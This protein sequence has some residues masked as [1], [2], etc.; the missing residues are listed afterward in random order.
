[1][2]RIFFK[3]KNLNLFLICMTLNILTLKMGEVFINLFLMRISSNVINVMIYNSAVNIFILLTCFV[4]APFIKKYNNKLGLLIGNAVNLL[5]YVTIIV[6]YKNADEYLFFLSIL[7]GIAN[8]FFWLSMNT[9]SIDLVNSEERL[10]FNS[11]KGIMNSISLMIGP[12][13][14]SLIIMQFDLIQGYIVLFVVIALVISIALFLSIFIKVQ[15]SSKEFSIKKFKEHYNTNELKNYSYMT[16]KML[17]HEGSIITLTSVI[18][19]TYVQSEMI[20]SLLNCFFT[21]ICIITFYLLGKTKESRIK[22]YV[23]SIFCLIVSLYCFFKVPI[24]Y[25]YILIFMTLYAIASSISSNTSANFT[26][27][28]CLKNDLSGEFNLE[29]ITY[30][31]IWI[32]V[33]RSFGNGLIV[34]LF[35]LH[36]N[37]DYFWIYGVVSVVAYLWAIRNIKVLSIK[38]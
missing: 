6:L 14:A 22:I 20:F 23:F 35:Y 26:N 10:K 5:L 32:A 2:E 7:S 30:R 16:A 4:A 3:N 21:L 28:V 31:E 33:G 38:K 19:F 12:I 8:A 9:L 27:I 36:H 17:V 11:L 29:F 37:F 1:M 18:V 15:P 25:T 34:A 13:S 24:N